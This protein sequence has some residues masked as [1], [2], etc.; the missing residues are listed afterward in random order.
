MLYDIFIVIVLAFSPYFKSLY[1][2]LKVGTFFLTINV[3][4]LIVGQRFVPTA[5]NYYVLGNDNLPTKAERLSVGHH[6]VPI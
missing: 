4:L 6:I 1:Q 3:F 5:R 2:G